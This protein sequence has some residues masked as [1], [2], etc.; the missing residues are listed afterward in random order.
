MSGMTPP[1][2]EDDFARLLLNQA[3]GQQRDRAGSTGSNSYYYEEPSQLHSRQSTG[4]LNRQNSLHRHSSDS[5]SNPSHQDSFALNNQPTIFATSPMPVQDGGYLQQQQDV[6]YYNNGYQQQNDYANGQQAQ[7]NA[8]QFWTNYIQEDGQQQPPQLQ[9]QDQTFMQNQQTYPQYSQNIEND[10][11]GASTSY[12][13]LWSEQ[14]VQQ[15]NGGGYGQQADLGNGGW[16]GMN[17]N[18]VGADH[19]S[20]NDSSFQDELAEM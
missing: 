13:P 5:T 14:F 17:G 16:N 7:G 10:N 20:N 4:S 19:A 1:E 15:Q 6:A 8:D 18:P 11:T 12:N 3:K 2:M 9:Q